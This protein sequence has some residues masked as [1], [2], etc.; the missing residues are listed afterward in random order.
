VQYIRPIFGEKALS[1]PERLSETLP[2]ADL[3]NASDFASG[4]EFL[5][6]RDPLLHGSMLVPRFR[7]ETL[8]GNSRARRS[9][10]FFLARNAIYYGLKALGI[11][12]GEN[13]LV[14]SFHCAVVV[15]SILAYGARIVFYNIKRDCSPDF[16]D[17]AAKINNQTRA[18]LAINYFGFPQP[19]IEL[20]QFCKDNHLFF[21]EDCAHVLTGELGSG[22]LGSYGDVCI[23]SPRKFFPIHDGGKLVINNP[24]LRLWVPDKSNGLRSLLTAARK[25]GGKLIDD[26]P[27]KE[28]KKYLTFWRHVY[29]MMQHLRSRN[30]EDSKVIMANGIGSFFDA[31]LVNLGMSWISKYV[32]EN[33][34]VAEVVRRRR[35]NYIFLLTELKLVPDIEPLFPNLGDDICPLAFPVRVEGRRKFHAILRSRGIPAFGWDGVIH[36]GLP[37]QEF[38]DAAFLYQNLSLLP[39]HQSLSENDMRVMV[40]ALTIALRE[41]RPIQTDASND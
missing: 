37:L 20:Q 12:G 25:M 15:D 21:I 27:I 34:D 11:S 3:E 24:H 41:S 18:I 33:I 10:D 13:I 32:L 1:H 6:P 14:P 30:I 5:I 9:F 8:A 2:I 35:A 26:S 28:V 40:R 16:A 19:L 7:R 29:S 23:F 4:T 38:P 36:P 31:S 22:V 17:M 39:I